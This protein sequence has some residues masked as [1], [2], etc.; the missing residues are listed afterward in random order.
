MPPAAILECYEAGQRYFGENYVQEIC[1]KAPSLPSDI[2]WHFIGHLQTNKV[3][4]LIDSVPSLWCVEGVSSAKLATQVR[5]Y[6]SSIIVYSPRANQ[7]AIYFDS[8][9]NV[10]QPYQDLINS[11]FLFK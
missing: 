3:K 5:F 8:W 7:A 1:E 9:I 6:F 4:Q 10:G 2:R 11:M